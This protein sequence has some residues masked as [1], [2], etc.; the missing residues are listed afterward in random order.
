M[1]GPLY[2]SS[3]PLI[4]ATLAPILNCIQL[5]PQLYKTY[6]TQSSKDISLYSLSIILANSFFWSLHGYFI[7]DQSLF[8]ASIIAFSVNLSLITL[9]VFERKLIKFNAQSIYL[10]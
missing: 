1:Q 4:V 10:Q 6:V 2:L 8:I 9:V 7:A 3:L 5:L